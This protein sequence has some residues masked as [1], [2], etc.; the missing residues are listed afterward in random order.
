MFGIYLPVE[1]PVLVQQLCAVRGT[2]SNVVSQLPLSSRV[3]LT[4]NQLCFLV[5]QCDN[6]LTFLY[7]Y[8]C[9]TATLKTGS[10]AIIQRFWTYEVYLP[11]WSLGTIS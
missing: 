1:D 11:K 6:F 2:E 8:E 7:Q 5:C 9:I 10:P 3:N 4:G